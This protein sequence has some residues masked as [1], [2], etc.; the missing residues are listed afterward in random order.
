VHFEN[1]NESQ[2]RAINHLLKAEEF[3]I[4]QGPPGT[5]KTEVLLEYAKYLLQYEKRILLTAP[6]NTAVDLLTKKCIAKGLKVVRIGHPARISQ[7]LFETTLDS[8]IQKHREF[9]N[10]L[11]W[12]KE[13]QEIFKKAAKYKR[14]FTKED[15]EERKQNLKE[16]RELSKLAQK[17]LERITLDVLEKTQILTCT[18]SNLFRGVWKNLEFDTVI[19]D[20]CSQALEP[21][22]W[23]GV[24]KT[25][26]RI[27]LSGDSKQLPPT[28]F[29]NNFQATLFEK[30]LEVYPTP[31]INNFLNYQYR[32]HPNILEFSN[33]VFYNKNILSLKENSKKFL[34]FS[35][36]KGFIFIDTA[37]SDNNETWDIESQSYTNET[38]IEILYKIFETELENIKSASI[39]ILSPYSAQVEK[40][41]QRFS[42]YLT[43][44]N[45]NLEINTID[46]FQGSERDVVFLSLVRSNERKEIGFLNEFRRMNVAMTRAKEELVIIGD[47]ETLL[48]S[49]FYEQMLVHIQ[50]HGKWISIWDFIY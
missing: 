12:K 43:L 13:A 34:S 5:G 40:L 39:G 2:N 30:L 22:I 45:L 31:P 42:Q 24:F 41:K 49:P 15:R 32:M 7:E 36:E 4:L 48:H 44:N 46:S 27:I 20:E 16:A 14:T 33:I 37:G 9:E 3:A 47:S 35:E 21:L 17:E 11:R 23:M 50:K 18:L 25:N 10:Y 29:S 28:T 8:Q 26:K 6:S 38:E 1:L 19:V